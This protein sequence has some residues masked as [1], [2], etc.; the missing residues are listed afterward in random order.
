MICPDCGSKNTGVIDCS[1][2]PETNEHSRLR[3]CKDCLYRFYSIEFVIEPN[4]QFK[5]DWAANNRY[6]AHNAKKAEQRRLAKE[7]KAK[8]EKKA[9]AEN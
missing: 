3:R 8:K 7:N 6:V 1:F 9:N 2:N 4:A 5:K